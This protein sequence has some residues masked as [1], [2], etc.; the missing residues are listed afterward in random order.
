MRVPLA[1]ITWLKNERV[2]FKHKSAINMFE[3]HHV[4]DIGAVMVVVFA[5]NVQS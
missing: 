1:V 3:F 2:S 5:L 4:E